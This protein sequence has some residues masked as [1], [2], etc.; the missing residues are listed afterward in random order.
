MW[1]QSVYITNL[2]STESYSIKRNRLY[3][4][5]H[6]ICFNNIPK[7]YYLIHKLDTIHPSIIN[8]EE[9]ESIEIR[10]DGG[11]RSD[12]RMLCKDESGILIPVKSMY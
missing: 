12:F 7:G 10:H 8:Y 9:G 3:D 4:G 5:A 11:D 1:F 2:S 6:K